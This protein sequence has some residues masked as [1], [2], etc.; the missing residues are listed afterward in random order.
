MCMACFGIFWL[1][2]WPFWRSDDADLL[3]VNTNPPEKQRVVRVSYIKHIFGL[4]CIVFVLKLYFAIIFIYLYH[5]LK[6]KSVSSHLSPNETVRPQNSRRPHR[7]TINWFYPLNLMVSAGKITKSNNDFFYD[8]PTSH[9]PQDGFLLSWNEYGWH[10]ANNPA[11]GAALPASSRTHQN[12]G[13]KSADATY[14]RRPLQNAI[15]R[16]NQ[17][18]KNRVLW[19]LSKTNIFYLHSLNTYSV[20]SWRANGGF[21]YFRRAF[22]TVTVYKWLAN[23]GIRDDWHTQL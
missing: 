12:D 21:F 5:A 18:D 9:T 7:R 2:F 1:P 10:I 4:Y 6:T 17:H 19:I 22:A 11:V 23:S 8:S 20:E 16:T 14:C 15:V 3:F 13:A